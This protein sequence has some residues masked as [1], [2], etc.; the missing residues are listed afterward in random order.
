MSSSSSCLSRYDDEITRFE[1]IVYASLTL[2]VLNLVL[3]RILQARGLP[4]QRLAWFLGGTGTL[5][6]GLSV[7][8]F[9]TIPTCPSGCQCTGLGHVN[10]IVGILPLV[11]GLLWLARGYKFY[12]SAQQQQEEQTAVTTEESLPTTGNDETAE[13][14]DIV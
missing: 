1:N 13:T 4:P 5:K 11:I 3:T 7:A 9:A 8:I 6:I 10:P 14:N 2:T 12:K